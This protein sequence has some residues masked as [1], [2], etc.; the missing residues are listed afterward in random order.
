MRSDSGVQGEPRFQ[1]AQRAW[2]RTHAVQLS[3]KS[4]LRG[5]PVRGCH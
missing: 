4:V 2:Q 5:R 1:H 3:T